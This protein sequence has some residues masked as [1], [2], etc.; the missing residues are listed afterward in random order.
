MS[1]HWTKS[2]C[3]YCGFGYGLMVGV[4]KGKV[5]KITGMKGHPANDGDICILPANHPPIFV[6][7]TRFMGS[8]H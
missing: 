7:R 3:P 4:E 1:I 8:D 6:R 5:V 2:T